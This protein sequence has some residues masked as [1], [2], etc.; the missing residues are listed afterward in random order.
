MLASFLKV[1]ALQV[2]SIPYSWE[3]TGKYLSDRC[4]GTESRATIYRLLVELIMHVR[5]IHVTKGG[6][7]VGG[8]S[9]Q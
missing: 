9:S 3:N 2:K 6:H 7:M 1:F 5:H 8:A 4:R